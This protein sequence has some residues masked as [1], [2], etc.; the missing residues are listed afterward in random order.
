M[1]NETYK[2]INRMY[3]AVEYVTESLKDHTSNIK[4]AEI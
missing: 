4:N 1:I 2:N 3:E